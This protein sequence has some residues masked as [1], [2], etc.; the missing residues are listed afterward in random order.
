MGG[1]P[2]GGWASGRGVS[3][4]AWLR[5]ME[6][7]SKD[8][9]R[10]ANRGDAA[11]ARIGAVSQRLSLDAAQ[12]ALA[13]E[14][15]FTSWAR[16]KTEVERHAIL[17]RRDV[18]RLVALLAEDP[19]LA[20]ARMEHW[21]AHPKGASPL[22]YVAMLRYDPS[23]DA[24][25][26]LSGTG[27]V[28]RALLDAGAP[29]DGDPGEPETPLITAAS[30]GDAEVARALIEAGADLEAT[31]A[32]DAGGIPG[33]TSLLHAA[34]FGMT[35]V[36]DVLVAAGARIH[37]LEEAAAAGDV[38]GWLNAQAPL[39]ARIRALVMAADHQRLPVIDQLIAAGTP[40][41]AVDAQ[42]GGHALR[43]AASNGRAASVRH[44]LAHGAD[45][46]LRDAEHHRTPLDWCRH[47][48]A[49]GDSPGHEQ[50]E[51]MLAALT[52]PDPPPRAEPSPQRPAP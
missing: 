49:T 42:W 8:L 27:A 51:A 11:L 10:A 40:V 15:G 26:D 38:S 36:V 37:S 5:T 4:I 35:G 41:D 14:H 19:A 48:R 45:P 23:R 30:Y 16:L 28:A 33:G 24:W 22:G 3:A 46:N 32:A 47:S 50:V 1:R 2:S 44:L 25:R 12:L 39:E 17:D 18:P 9:L 31:A 20:T 43:T 52:S 34:V 29:V 6:L 21:C 13:R 7:A